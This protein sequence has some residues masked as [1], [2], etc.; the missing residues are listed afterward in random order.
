MKFKYLFFLS[1][2]LIWGCNDKIE[3]SDAFGNFE[4]ETVVVSSEQAG[5]ILQMNVEKGQEIAAGFIA[6]IIDTIQLQLKINQLVAQKAA[7]GTRNQSVKSQIAVLDEQMKTLKINQSRM[8]E[9]LKDGAATQKQMD[10]LLGQISVTE[11]QNL[12][13]QTQFSSIRSEMDV[14]ETQKAAILDQIERCKIKSPISGTVLETY[15]EIGE[16]ATPGKPLFKMAN[17]NELTLKVYVS[18]AQLPEIKIGESVNVI[19][20]KSEKEN[21]SIQGKIIWISPEAEF[22]PKIIQTKEERVKLV[23]AVKVNVKND[24]RLKI[25]M[26]GEISFV[27]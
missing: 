8:T 18:G 11:K 1:I 13:T 12:S 20:D 2:T 27:H 26:P 10:D 24:G 16:L 14:I 4:A 22:T 23:Y 17:L 25:G 3:K 6:A 19:F 5:K 15:L 21:Q 9:M 7:I